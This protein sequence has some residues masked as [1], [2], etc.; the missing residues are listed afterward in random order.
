MLELLCAIADG[1]MSDR[2]LY[3][4]SYGQAKVETGATGHALEK[5]GLIQDHP[6]RDGPITT[7]VAKMWERGEQRT[8]Q[9]TPA[10]EAV[11]A[12]L[13]VAGIFVEADAAIM[14]RA[15]ERV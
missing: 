15:R 10:G 13:R 1:V 3:F 4:Q 11:V 6:E 5:R 7:E 9:L 12:L 2:R 14:K 8:W